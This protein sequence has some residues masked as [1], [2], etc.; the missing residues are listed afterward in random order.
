MCRQTKTLILSIVMIVSILLGDGIMTGEAV[1]VSTPVI[2]VSVVKI[3]S[4]TDKVVVK[5]LPKVEKKTV[6]KPKFRLSE[7]EIHLIAL[8]TM[9]EAEG[10]PELGQRLVIDTI[11][12]RVDSPHFSKTVNDVIYAPNQF[13]SMQTSRIKKC[14]I[15][16]ELVA[17]VKE[18]LVKQT[19]KE[20]V[21]FRLDHYSSYGIPLFK[22]GNHY[23]SKYK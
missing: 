14:Y 22:V 1:K 3:I 16:E 10:E 21:Y 7:K 17:L 9:A 6:K 20:V 19:N 12:C 8:V 4:K 13:T 18:E 23:F 15:K 11:L 2:P 5:P